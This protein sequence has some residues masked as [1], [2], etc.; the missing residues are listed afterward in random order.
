MNIPDDIDAQDNR[1]FGGF[2]AAWTA[3]IQK[4]AL[5]VLL[6]AAGLGALAIDYTVRNLAMNTSTSDMIDART[7][8]RQNSDAFERAFPQFSSLLVIVLDGPNPEA[9]QNAAAALART[10]AA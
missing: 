5:L 9:T 3:L 10:L 6:L 1:G 7:S 4:F 2:L 8:F